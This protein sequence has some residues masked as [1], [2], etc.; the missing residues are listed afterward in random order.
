MRFESTLWLP[1]PRQEVFRFFADAA[2]LEAITPP[3]LGFEVVTPRPIEMRVGALIEYR[4]R[5]HGV[6]VSWLISARSCTE[7]PSAS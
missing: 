5:L 7:G 6:P 2:N 1:R 3:W 4:L